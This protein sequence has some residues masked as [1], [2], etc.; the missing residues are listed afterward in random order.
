MLADAMGDKD[1][2][3]PAA[4]YLYV[5]NPDELYEKALKAGGKSVMEPADQFYGDRN[6]GV[7]DPAGNVWWLATKIEEI[8]PEEMIRRGKEWEKKVAH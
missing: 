3:M 1:S 7:R 4:L 8:S 6:A 5:P 2:E